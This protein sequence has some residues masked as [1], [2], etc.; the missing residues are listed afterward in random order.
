M[1]LLYIMDL[2]QAMQFS[3]VNNKLLLLP[4]LPLLMLLLFTSMEQVA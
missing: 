2:A 4:L 1:L 3:G